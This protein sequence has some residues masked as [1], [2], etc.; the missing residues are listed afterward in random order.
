LLG[1]NESGEEYYQSIIPPI[2]PKT[3]CTQFIPL[4]EPFA[5]NLS[6]EE[7]QKPFATSH[8]SSVIGRQKGK[9]IRNIIELGHD[10]RPLDRP[11]C[12]ILIYFKVS[13]LT[14]VAEFKPHQV[15][16]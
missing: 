3:I 1:K 15:L 10:G 6:R 2:R 7:P 9:R 14:G 16:H 4:Y 11:S 13:E 8:R 12:H 5:P